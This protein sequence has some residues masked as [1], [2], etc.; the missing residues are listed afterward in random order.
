MPMDLMISFLQTEMRKVVVGGGPAGI[1]AAATLGSGTI[2][3]EAESYLGGT[4]R[5]AY[6]DTTM[7]VQHS[8]QIL[9]DYPYVDKLFLKLT[10]FPTPKHLLMAAHDSVSPLLRYAKVATFKDYLN[11][12]PLTIRML[13]G[14]TLPGN[15]TASD[16]ASTLS[17]NLAEQVK[18]GAILEAGPPDKVDVQSLV[19]L[20]GT[21]AWNQKL[22]HMNS[23][24][25]WSSLQ[26]GLEK[27][28]VDVMCS[29]KVV[30]LI[31]TKGGG[32]VEA[33]ELDDGTV[34]QGDVFYLCLPPRALWRLLQELPYENPFGAS[35]R[36]SQE[37][38]HNW[39]NFIMKYDRFV[40]LPA[41]QHWYTGL[42]GA[43]VVID[44]GRQ[45]KEGFSRLAVSWC[46]PTEVSRHEVIA[47]LQEK[48]SNLKTIPYTIASSSTVDCIWLGGKHRS[49]QARDERLS[50]LFVG[51]CFTD[52][53]FHIPLAET[54]IRGA[55]TMLH[56]S[57]AIPRS[58][59]G[60]VHNTLLIASRVF[61]LIFV[62]VIYLFLKLLLFALRSQR[63][64][65]ASLEP[66]HR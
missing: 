58:V 17:P 14:C 39:G 34:I 64:I 60:T 27:L 21:T 4:W 5:L 49:I 24:R 9:F 56:E 38:S 28:G 50:N 20:L 59:V 30:R 8:P 44:V 45:Y 52:P 32:G 47:G 13:F 25:E 53:Y 11:L 61:L 3:I 15:Y 7:M 12:A 35:F 48:V 19:D 62:I 1:A 51:S 46:Y 63:T 23:P 6:A 55:L 36:W 57:S 18:M 2:L 29:R 33:V 65:G 26:T 40:E 43:P 41:E 66:T 42:P 54:A 22:Y 10:G 31:A 37:S 16:L